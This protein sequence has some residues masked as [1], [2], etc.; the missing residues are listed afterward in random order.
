MRGDVND[1]PILMFTGFFDVESRGPFETFQELRDDGS[2]LLVIG[3]HDGAPEGSGGADPAR[4]RWFDR[5]LRAVDNGV[6]RRPPV[7]PWLPAGPPPGPL[8]GA[9]TRTSLG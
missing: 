1:L 8:P 2:H 6:D 4:Q 9:P 3:A 7:H 5:H